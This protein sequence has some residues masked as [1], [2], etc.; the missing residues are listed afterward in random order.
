MNPVSN[1][2]LFF[3]RSYFIAPLLIYLRRGGRAS[4]LRLASGGKA[5]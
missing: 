5:A 4:H 3:T 2:A 1:Y